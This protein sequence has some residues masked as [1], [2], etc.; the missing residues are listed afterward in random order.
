MA[1]SLARSVLEVILSSA[2]A[3][4]VTAPSVPKEVEFGPR[5][6][7]RNGLRRIRL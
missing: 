4:E 3:D 7:E 2:V 6:R 5:A 1:V